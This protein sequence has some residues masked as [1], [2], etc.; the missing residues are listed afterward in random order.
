MLHDRN[1]AIGNILV[2]SSTILATQSTLK[3]VQLSNQFPFIA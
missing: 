2:C 3:T 1:K